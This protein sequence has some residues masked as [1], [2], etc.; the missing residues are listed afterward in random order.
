MSDPDIKAKNIKNRREKVLQGKALQVY[1]YLLTHRRAGVREI[2]KALK[3]VSP[4]TASYQIDK[5]VKAGIISKN[6]EDGKYYV[7]ESVKRG[8]LGFYFRLGPLMIPRFSLY[9]SIN[10]LSVI[11][12]LFFVI[13]YGNVFI[14][15]PGGLLFMFLL[16]FCTFVFAFESKKIWERKP[17]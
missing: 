8:V 6:N 16:I 10:I 1:W 15:S 12:Y 7:K 2:Q 14:A 4:G 3:M 11:G 5:L 13:T 9:L 17:T